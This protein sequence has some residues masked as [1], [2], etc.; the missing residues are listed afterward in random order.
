MSATIDPSM[1]ISH[2]VGVNIGGKPKNG[3]QNRLEQDDS[4]L[5]LHMFGGSKKQNTNLNAYSPKV[6]AYPIDPSAT[7]SFI[8]LFLGN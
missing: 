1:I 6:V 5:L 8:I 3:G 2:S 7:R 4:L